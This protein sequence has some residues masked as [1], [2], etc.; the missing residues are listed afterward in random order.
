MMR[1]N[2][3]Q[4]LPSSHHAEGF[5]LGRFVSFQIRLQSHTSQS[6]SEGFAFEVSG[7]GIGLKSVVYH[8][9]LQALPSAGIPLPCYC[10]RMVFVFKGSYSLA[11]AF[12][13]RKRCLICPRER[14]WLINDS[15][16]FSDET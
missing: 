3:I 15:C 12:S 4:A 9:K 6:F 5:C 11:I 8:M 16:A 7:A 10:P 2:G 13:F 14:K 1:G